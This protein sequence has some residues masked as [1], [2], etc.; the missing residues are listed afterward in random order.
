[1]QV[2]FNFHQATHISQLTNRKLILEIYINYRFSISPLQTYTLTIVSIIS[3]KDG[4]YKVSCV[5]LMRPLQLHY[6]GNAFHVP[7]PNILIQCP[8][9]PLHTD[10]VNNRSKRVVLVAHNSHHQ[11]VEIFHYHRIILL[12]SQISRLI[13]HIRFSL[14]TK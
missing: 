6:R 2:G 13:L 4:I 10:N 12:S 3:H 9:S 5:Y 8:Y 1:M 7:S 14:K 11:N